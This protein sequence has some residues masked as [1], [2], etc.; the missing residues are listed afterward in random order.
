MYTFAIIALLALA[1]VKLVDVLCDYVTP[2]A[3]LRSLVTFV[4][5]IGGVWAL[6]FSMFAGFDTAVRDQDVAVLITGLAVA[7]VTVAWR[8]VFAYLTHD[9]ATRDETLGEHTTLHRAA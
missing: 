3:R 6:D 1:T 8:A 9:Q 4:A 2:L 7:G 5:A